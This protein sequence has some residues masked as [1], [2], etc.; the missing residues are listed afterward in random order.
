[1]PSRQR[2]AQPPPRPLVIYDGD[3]GFCQTWIARWQVRTGDAVDYEPS[4]DAGS[5]F[6]E[7][8]PEAF[9]RSVQLVLPDGSVFA[10]AEAVAAL[11]ALPSGR[12][13]FLWMY[14]RVP[15]ARA[16]AELAYRLIARHRGAAAAMTRLLWGRSVLRPTY[17]AANALFLRLLGLCYLAAFC[18]VLDPGRRPGGLTR[19][20]ARRLL[21]RLGARPDRSRALLAASHAVLDR[22]RPTGCCTRSAPAAS[23][24]RSVCS[25]AFFRRRLPSLAWLF[26]LSLTVAGQVFLQ[27]QWDML[28]L[29]AGLLAIFLAPPLRLR[30]RPRARRA[31]AL[32][33][34]A[35]LAALSPD[36]LL[37]LGQAHERRPDLAE[38]D[39]APVPLRDPAAPALDRVVRASAS[40]GFQ[41][42]SCLF[43]FFVELVVPFFFFA[44]RRLRLFA[45][46][47]TVF[48][49]VVIAA[50]G[51]YAF[52]NLLTIALAVL[53]LDDASLPGAVA[54]P[55]RRRGPRPRSAGRAG[56]SGRRP[57]SSSPPRP[58]R[59]SRRSARG[60][61]FRRRCCGCTASSRRCAAPT[62]TGS[63]P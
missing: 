9:A 10:G 16:A 8:P 47:L 21:S 4:Q 48:L 30:A 27:F 50:T 39:G 11:A 54:R 55:G 42:F 34:P 6:P 60:D 13:V 26:Y 59:S 20:P 33:I 52:F 56:S 29:E 61:P 32:A 57:R 53:L 24:R 12:G 14:R 22:A 25:P 17:L 41:T 1:M 49:Q 2:V 7:I 45:C 38:P 35:G 28:L 40:A 63:S 62:A 15:G 51:N 31:R 37:G 36:V 3:C 58:F 19:D 43:L 18:L 46:G 44:P 23:P 5:R